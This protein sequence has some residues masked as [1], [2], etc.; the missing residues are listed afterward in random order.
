MRVGNLLETKQQAK[1]SL[2]GGQLLGD[3]PVSKSR[4][5]EFTDKL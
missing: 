4:L 5:T 1:V 2:L 3:T